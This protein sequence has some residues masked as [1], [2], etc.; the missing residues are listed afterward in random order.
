MDVNECKQFIEEI[1]D[2]SYFEV[3]KKTPLNYLIKVGYN[4]HRASGVFLFDE[5]KEQEIRTKYKNGSICGKAVDPLLAQKYIGNALLLDRHN[6]FDFR[7][8]MLIAS[9]DPLILFYHDG[10]LR[11]SLVEYDNHSTDV[12][13]ALL[14][15]L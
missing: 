14:A 13:F 12:N 10:F 9:V 5:K 8:Y 3:K 15:C 7:M 4:A 1:N 2:H 11:V 6:K